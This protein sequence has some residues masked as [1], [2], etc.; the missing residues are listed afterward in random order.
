[1]D[2]APHKALKEGVVGEQGTTAII[3]PPD[4]RKTREPERSLLY[5]APKDAL[6]AE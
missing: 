1:V 6:E 4:E 5:L 3:P 2:G